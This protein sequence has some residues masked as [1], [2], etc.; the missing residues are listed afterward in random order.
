MGVDQGFRA[1][2]GEKR[3]DCC[4]WRKFW[5]LME[6]MFDLG[7]NR[8]PFPEQCSLHFELNEGDFAKMEEAITKGKLKE[9]CFC[10]ERREYWVD[11]GLIDETEFGPYSED[12][13]CSCKKFEMIH[14]E[15]LKHLYSDGYT[16]QYY[17]GC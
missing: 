10:K 13:D 9:E 8:D 17:F 15:E 1:T 11:L 4:S 6:F 5:G 14:L 3:V 7:Q 16:I 2:K 12:E